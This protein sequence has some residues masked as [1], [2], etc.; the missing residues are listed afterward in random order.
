MLKDNH[1]ALID[2]LNNFNI[3]YSKFD[4]IFH[5]NLMTS[6]KNKKL[7]HYTMNMRD[8]VLEVE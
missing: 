3:E 6:Q 2:V 7:Y 1:L 4:D 8:N 5:L